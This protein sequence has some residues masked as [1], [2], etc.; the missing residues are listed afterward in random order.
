[1][2]FSLVATIV[3]AMSSVDAF[4]PATPSRQAF[5]LDASAAPV[6]DPE[7]ADAI[8]EVRAAASAFSDETA[9][10]ANVWIDRVLAG[11]Q[12]GVPSGL[13]EEC[14]IDDG[15]EKCQAFEQALKRLDSMVGVGAGEQY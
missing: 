7:L 10:F 13:L 15:G 5:A 12:D 8:A 3:A 1:M 11:D 6:D 4:V 9:H 14:L 2:K